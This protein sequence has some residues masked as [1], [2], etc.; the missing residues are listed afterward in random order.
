[1]KPANELAVQPK[2]LEIN[3][4]RN[5]SERARQRVSNDERN[6]KGNI[7]QQQIKLRHD[8][9]KQRDRDDQYNPEDVPTLLHTAADPSFSESVSLLNILATFAIMIVVRIPVACIC[10]ESGIIQRST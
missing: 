8:Q 2:M 10:N 9:A 6:K 3:M 5:I 1:M 4:T 7:D